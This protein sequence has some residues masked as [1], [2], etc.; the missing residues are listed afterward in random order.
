MNPKVKFTCMIPGIKESYP[1][2]PISH[3]R[4][5]WL[6]AETYD[7]VAA[8][9][10]YQENN[11]WGIVKN[12]MSIA[13]CTGLRKLYTTGWVLTT[14]QDIL[15][16][17]DQETGDL[18]WQT[19][20]D[21]TRKC[22]NIGPSIVFHNPDTFKHCPHLAK[23]PH[24]LKIENPWLAKLPKG[25]SMLQMP[26]PY[27]EHDIFQV[28]TGIFP[29]EMGHMQLNVQMLWKAPGKTL[30]PAGTP[31]VH[32]ILIKNEDYEYEVSNITPEEKHAWDA[33][34]II[35]NSTWERNYTP[36]K[37]S[38]QKVMDKLDE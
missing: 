17:Y 26:F 6:D 27:Q 2:K 31:L 4:P 1:I 13:K 19:P 12:G 14:W 10:D 25:Y 30:I 35:L 37:E 29:E 3:F 34:V 5:Y 15:I 24:I 36:I 22:D 28:A 33:Q 23:I 16:D 11:P 38:I 20:I 21:Q 8:R 7:Y 18:N 32:L 9:K